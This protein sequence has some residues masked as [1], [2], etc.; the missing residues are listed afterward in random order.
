MKHNPLDESKSVSDEAVRWFARLHSGDAT[1][2]TRRQFEA[3]RSSSPLHAL[4]YEGIRA[5]WE[6]L[7]GIKTGP[8][9]KRSRKKTVSRPPVFPQDKLHKGG[10]ARWG[11]SL[12][13]MLLLFLGGSFWLS[14]AWDHL[15]SDFYTNPG[16]LKTL[17]L[18]DGSK[19]YLDAD[20]ALSVDFS[21]QQRRLVLDRGGALFVVS[22]DK[23][24]PFEVVA[25]EG[26]VRA[27]GTAFE[28]R[29]KLDQVIVKV[30]D[31]EVQ[32]TRDF[33]KVNLVPGQKIHYGSNTG[34][35]E[36]ESVDRG[37]IAI[38]RRGK[39]AF[40]NQQ[41]GEV[42]NEVNRYRKGV[43]L[44]LDEKLRTS[45]VSGIFDISDPDAV[46]RALQST[47]P[48]R[49]HRVTSYLVFIDQTDSPAPAL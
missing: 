1:E 11:T 46:L 16:E 18:A 35:S 2:D 42:I 15:A 20:S 28:V 10:M 33:S 21:P 23:K 25:G 32:V 7:D 43:I 39:L 22:E 31:S 37:Q 3:W 47:L 30:L 6:D 4:E 36:V 12:V 19:V 29:K 17:N 9:H 48:I 8:G 5:V 44:I 27:L 13:A 34:L 45:R 14:D 40:D 24:R 49:V 26:T 41:L 38:W